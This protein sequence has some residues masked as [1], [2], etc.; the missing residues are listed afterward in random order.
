MCDLALITLEVLLHQWLRHDGCH[1][2]AGLITF[3]YVGTCVLCVCCVCCVADR[4]FCMSEVCP[5]HT[6]VWP[7]L[8]HAMLFLPVLLRL[9]WKH[10]VAR[11][12][13]AAAAA[14]LPG[15][16]QPVSRL[17]TACILSSLMA[18]CCASGFSLVYGVS[19]ICSL[20]I[21]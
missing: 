4:T 6:L 13:A 16:V 10:G 2:Y 5:L 3:V 21:F 8:Q 14:C 12:C 19:P 17:C 15:L 9:Y 20:P 18:L 7:W 11:C 1:C